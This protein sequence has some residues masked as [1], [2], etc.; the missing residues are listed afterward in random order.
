MMRQDPEVIAV[1]EIRDF[2][3]AEVAFQ[4]SLTGHLVLCTF[5]AGS[6]A[7]VIGRLAEMGIEPYVMSSGIRAIVCQR[8]VR[9]LCTCARPV[10]DQLQFLGLNVSRARIAA[11]CDVCR[12]TGYR[13]R[14]SLAEILSPR[15]PEISQAIR[16]QADVNHLE[17][18]ALKAGMV[19]LYQRA[20][21]SVEAGLT[22][23]AEVRRVL[24]I[25]HRPVLADPGPV[26]ESR[27]FSFSCFLR[28]I[29]NCPLKVEIHFKSSFAP[30]DRRCYRRVCRLQDRFMNQQSSLRSSRGTAGPRTSPPKGESR[31]A[32]GC[33]GAMFA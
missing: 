28:L 20:L 30:L 24:G 5:H 25:S 11:G 23:P 18:I 14:I 4:A 32:A 17:A 16:S 13:G 7:G 21:L 3:T 19:S 15:H 27:G 33:I 12:G 8:L 1:G 2:A 22:D 6:A 9:R 29:C 26:A 31:R 10:D